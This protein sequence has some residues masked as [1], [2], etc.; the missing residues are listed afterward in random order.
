MCDRYAILPGAQSWVSVGSSLGEGLLVALR[1]MPPLAEAR[2]TQA[3]PV[4]FRDR[5]TRQVVGL[6]ARWSLVPSFWKRAELPGRSHLVWAP[7][8]ADK[9]MWRASWRYYRCLMPVTHWWQR[10]RLP[11]G[12][13]ASYRFR[14][15]PPRSADTGLM[16]AGLYAYWT[17]PLSGSLLISC[18]AL[19]QP[20]RPRFQTIAARQPVLLEP[21]S[22]RSWLDPAVVTPQAVAAICERGA[23]QG[24]MD[25]EAVAERS[26]LAPVRPEPGKARAELAAGDQ[27]AGIAGPRQQDFEF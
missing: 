20:A 23:V 19:T 26:L 10:Q 13:F 8:L 2:P 4:I 22:W 21:S 25:L 6:P 9:P 12:G 17:D 16:W 11:G 1:A 7:E 27:E 24:A 14:P 15:A 18:A 3:V 5:E